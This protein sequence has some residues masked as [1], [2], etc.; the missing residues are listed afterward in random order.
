MQGQRGLLL[1]VYRNGQG[2]YD[3]VD[4]LEQLGLILGEDGLFSGQ[5]LGQVGDAWEVE[6]GES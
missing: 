5:V 6:E 3:L 4:M 1:D 2:G